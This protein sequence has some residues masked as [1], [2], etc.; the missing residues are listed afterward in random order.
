[1]SSRR[2]DPATPDPSLVR[3]L[4]R[5]FAIW[6]RL[7]GDETLTLEELPN[8]NVWFRRTRPRGFFRR[9]QPGGRALPAPIRVCYDRARDAKH[10]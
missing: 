9:A 8:R 5:A 10:S 2:L 7:L 3:V 4:V 1:M 6:N